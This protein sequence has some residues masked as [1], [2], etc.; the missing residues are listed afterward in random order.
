MVKAA[1]RYLKMLEMAARKRGP[2][3]FSDLHVVDYC[4]FAEKF[5]HFESG[6]WEITQVDPLTGEPDPR[7]ILEPWQIWSEAAI[8]G[9]RHVDHGTRIVSMALECVPRKNA[10][11]LKASIAGLYDLCC[12]GQ[13]APEI[14]VAAS[15]VRQAKDTLFGDMLKMVANEPELKAAYDIDV[16]TQEIRSGEGRIFMVTS[17]GER[18]DGLNPSLALFEEGHSNA[19]SVWDVIDSAFGARPNAL[20]RMITTAGYTPEG[21]AWDLIAYAK[22]VLDGAVED[23]SFFGAIYTLD[24]EDY[25]DPESSAIDWNRLLTN[26]KLVAKANPMYGISLDR[27]SVMSA[28]AKAKAQPVNRTEFARTRFNIWS[29]SGTSLI[30]LSS[31]MACK[32]DIS[33]EHFVRKRCWIGV[34]LATYHD[35]CAVV[36]LFE[37]PG[38]VLACFAHF[39]LPEAS[40][41]VQDPDMA[42]RY[43]LWAEEGWLTLTE[44]AM[45]DHDRVEAEIENYCKWFRPEVI[46]CDPWQAHNTVK[47]LWDGKKP[48]MTYPNSEKTMTGPT[49][50]LLGRIVSQKL[51]HDGNPMLAHHAVNVYGER[52]GNG[53]ILPRKEKQNSKRKIDGFVALCFAN[54][55]RMQ[56]E[57]AKSEKDDTPPEDPY[58]KRGIIGYEQIM[59]EKA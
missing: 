42:D 4:S 8:H 2:F 39:F 21:P 55:V 3:R 43:R 11:S 51:L 6:N 34:D 29:G 19:R 13:I 26:E 10:K 38:D 17:I 37:M 44:G 58:L 16:T 40:E 28:C 24:E 57:F 15:S 5:S 20:R 27:A 50:D 35:S 25:L 1:R 59:G 45:A 33:L 54:G 14:P 32:R 49:D 30:E 53:G 41:T 36:L 52:R 7:I 56:P 9:F 47:H 46:A 12:S 23:W 48:V 18:L 31:W 22:M